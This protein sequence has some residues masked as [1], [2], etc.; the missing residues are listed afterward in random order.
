M[1]KKTATVSF[2]TESFTVPFETENDLFL[3]V[4]KASSKALPG[5]QIA[6]VCGKSSAAMQI[7]EGQYP[8]TR[9]KPLW[10][11]LDLPRTE[12]KEK[13]LSICSSD[14]QYEMY[15]LVPNSIGPYTVTFTGGRKRIGAAETDLDAS[16][17]IKYPVPA[18]MM[19][20]WI[21]FLLEK[22]YLDVTD[23][24]RAASPANDAVEEYAE[25]ADSVV[26]QVYDYLS[27][28][29]R[30]MAGQVFASPSG[31]VDLLS[32]K[33]HFAKTQ[34]DAAR[35]VWN[36]LGVN[37]GLANYVSAVEAQKAGGLTGKALQS[38][39]SDAAALYFPAA[40][41]EFNDKLHT[42]MTISPRRIDKWHGGSVKSFEAKLK[43]TYEKQIEEF[44]VI[45]EREER[46]IKIMES[47]M[48]DDTPASGK[49]EIF[50]GILLEEASDDEVSFVKSKLSS[51]ADEIENVFRI[52]DK[53]RTQSF[54]SYC[55]EHAIDPENPDQTYYLWHGS[56]NENWLSI[57]ANG[58]MLNPNA[59]ITGK[60]FGCGIYFAPDPDKSFGYTSA[61][62]SRW[63]GGTSATAFM[64]LYET[65]IG[66]QFHP[67]HAGQYTQQYLADNGFDSLWA[68]RQ[69]TSLL[70][71]EVVL[72]SEKAMCLRYLVEFKIRN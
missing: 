6:I 41:K 25:N 20:V 34:V 15:H 3:E 67:A 62:G 8:E 68:R 31:N 21:G 45:V 23:S 61:N 60:M 52:T 14:N 11:H 53:A 43:K 56:V 39:A 12:Y 22:G 19:N 4:G 42:L 71:D 64:G 2:G 46:Y 10:N 16:W 9:M 35:S 49:N 30:Q 17:N 44:S 27:A 26:R 65:A 51:H 1:D 7:L 59:A 32:T 57:I 47:V 55:R 72:F 63:A 13:Y 28:C 69:D 29:S 50:P 40:V 48:I 58:L 33:I 66:K 54:L 5:D 24:I 38:F 37:Q 70:R 18:Y 36:T